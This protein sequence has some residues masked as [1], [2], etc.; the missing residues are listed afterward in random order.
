MRAM[1]HAE[2][3]LNPEKRKST[4]S[5]LVQTSDLLGDDASRRK[6]NRNGRNSQVG[7]SASPEDQAEAMDR[8]ADDGWLPSAGGRGP[9]L[10]GRRM[11]GSEMLGGGGA[12]GAAQAVRAQGEAVGTE[13]AQLTEELAMLKSSIVYL[14]AKI[15]SSSSSTV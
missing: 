9:G 14:A 7:T 8:A 1:Q 11:S 5:D 13:M 6:S 10:G 15:E 4:T 3:S 2:R 12:L